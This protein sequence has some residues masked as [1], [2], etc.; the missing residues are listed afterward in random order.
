M[1]KVGKVTIPFKELDAL[2]I[3]AAAAERKSKI[4]LTEC[5]IH[6]Q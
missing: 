4:F 3:I 1:R 5:E 6:P 2:V